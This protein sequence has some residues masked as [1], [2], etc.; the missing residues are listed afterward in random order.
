MTNTD[1][2][3]QRLTEMAVDIKR[4]QG[5][6]NALHEATHR[7]DAAT[8]NELLLS[9]EETS[10]AI[11]RAVDIFDELVKD[12]DSKSH[13]AAG[14]VAEVGD[15]L[16]LVLME[17]TELGTGLYSLRSSD[18]TL[19]ASRIPEPVEFAVSS[20]GDTWLL[21]PAEGDS[22]ALVEHRANAPSGGAI[23]RISVTAFLEERPAGPQHD[24]LRALLRGQ[25]DPSAEEGVAT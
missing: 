19:E 13:I 25:A 7:P 22:P 17:I 14:Q 24:A 16:R 18:L 11:Y 23:T 6:A 21:C 8:D 12:V 20:N 9:V 4:W 2:L 5:D 15:A 10:S 3:R 1:D